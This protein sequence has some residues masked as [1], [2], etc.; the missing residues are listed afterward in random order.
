ME[1]VDR[2]TNMVHGKVRYS[3]T[4][5]ASDNLVVLMHG[6]TTSKDIYNHLTQDL[7][8]HGFQVLSFDFYGRGES[9]YVPNVESEKLYVN[10]AIE[11]IEKFI[12]TGAKR[13]INL[14]GYSAGGS[15]A[16]MVADRLENC[17]SLILIASTG[18]PQL[19]T[20]PVLISL[21]QTFE[22]N[23]EISSELKH[24]VEKQMI[25]ELEVLEENKTKEVKTND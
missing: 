3:I 10:Q 24:E 13:N 22:S 2:F 17:A 14:V 21:L 4:G 8:K 7:I 23:G 20:S 16:S 18:V 1:I 15:I 12:P 9:E 25:Q 6:L 19:P 5:E 11:L